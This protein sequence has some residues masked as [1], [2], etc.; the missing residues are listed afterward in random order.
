MARKHV[1][2][3]RIS[4]GHA[5]AALGGADPEALIELAIAR[6]LS[7]RELEAKARESRDNV[8]LETKSAVPAPAAEKDVDT[9]ALEADLSRELGLVVD[10]RHGRAGG[11]IRIKYRELEQLDEVCKRLTAKRRPPV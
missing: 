4:A 3:G 11:E 7:V 5:R 9:E 10:I 2:E 6:G 8:P 1:R